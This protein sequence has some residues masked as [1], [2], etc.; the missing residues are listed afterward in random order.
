MK[1]RAGN[2]WSGMKLRTKLRALAAVVAMVVAA[3]PVLT[4]AG[5]AEGDPA[6][7]EYDPKDLTGVWVSDESPFASTASFARAVRLMRPD[8][9]DYPEID[10][11]D[12]PNR[13]PTLPILFTPEFE[14]LHEQYRADHEAGR[15]Y[16]TGYMC[17]PNG[18]L[19]A[20]TSRMT[21]ELFGLPG[22]LMFNRP[23]IGWNFTVHM[24]RPHKT[25]FV[26][27]EL[28]GDSVGTWDGD[29]L[30]V[31]TVNL[32]GHA[33]MIETEPHSQS[34]HVVQRIRRPTYETLVVDIV[35][36]DPRAFQEP[37]KFHTTYRLDNSVEFNEAQCWYDGGGEPMA[38][39]PE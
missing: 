33:V 36:D 3:T 1:L 34:L 30:V 25:E 32:G 38:H 4:R 12:Y 19:A 28:F 37:V 10:P 27:P 5:Q 14:A 16:R 15:P 2:V 11:R 8:L 21:V 20:I 29:T 13:H 35:A 39:A 23:L 6:S 7:P 9:Q 31:D 26:L 18:L 17:Q 22:R 24:D